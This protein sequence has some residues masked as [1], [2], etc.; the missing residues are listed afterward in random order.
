MGTIP[1]TKGLEPDVVKAAARATR[2]CRLHRGVYQR[3]TEL[4]PHLNTASA[5]VVLCLA[6]SPEPL[7]VTDIAERTGLHRTSVGHAV[8]LMQEERS[9]NGALL[10]PG[11]AVRIPVT[12]VS[13]TI[14]LTS[15]G[16]ELARQLVEK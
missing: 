15:L 16:E 4:Q 2:A 10:R 12:G 3:L 6:A 7:F 8:T 11:F 13:W 14:G 1:E 5:D 9:Y